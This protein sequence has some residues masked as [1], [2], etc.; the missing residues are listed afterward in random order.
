MIK[1]LQKRL[2]TS[3]IRE[4]YSWDL[5]GDSRKI[6]SVLFLLGR[7]CGEEEAESSPCVVMN[8]RS[9]LVSQAG[10]VC[11]PGGGLS[12][13]L[14]RTIAWFLTLPVFSLA[15][16][17]FWRWWLKY[18]PNQAEHMALFYAAALREGFEEMRLNPFGLTFLGSL[19]PQD[20]VLF[21]RVI[22][23]QTAWINR[24]KRFIPNWEVDRI[25]YL[26]LSELLNPS[27]YAR[28]RLQMSFRRHSHPWDRKTNEFLCYTH[29]RGSVTDI[30]WGAT[31]RITMDFLQII[32]GFQPPDADTLPV[33]DGLIDDTYL[34]QR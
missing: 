8:V 33:I 34:N 30:L 17:P 20:L 14:D 9:S 5:S 28:Y 23:P 24:Q 15:K 18:F 26:P 19:P 31:F 29:R 2:H 3:A 6:S 25:V 32:F 7:F 13:T 4:K 16:W 12:L 11:C 10:D 1:T 22:Y 27:N 21:K